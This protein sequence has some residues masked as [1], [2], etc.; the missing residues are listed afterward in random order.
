MLL[1]E[2]KKKKVRNFIIVNLNKIV[3][4]KFFPQLRHITFSE[5]TTACGDELLELNQDMSLQDESLQIQQDN[6]GFDL[7]DSHNEA[8]DLP[9]IQQYSGE[10][11]KMERSRIKEDDSL[12]E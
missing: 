6:K 5:L 1:Q 9:I 8:D 4:N 12:M 11:I 10:N 2:Q 7:I 3:L